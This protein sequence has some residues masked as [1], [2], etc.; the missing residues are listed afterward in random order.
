MDDEELIVEQS[1]AMVPVSEPETNGL[2][3]KE[4]AYKQTRFQVVEICTRLAKNDQQGGLVF[5]TRLERAIKAASLLSQ[6]DAA[7]AQAGFEAGMIAF[8]E[9]G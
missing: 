1:S 4:I 5:V 2:S 7:M 6:P 9:E 3:P 8:L